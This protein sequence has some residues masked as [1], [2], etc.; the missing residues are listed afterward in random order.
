MPR[1]AARVRSEAPVEQLIAGLTD[2]ELREV[3]S[4]AVDR[5]ADVERQV[6]LIA[7]RGAGDLA[8][9]RAEVDRGLRTRRFLDYGESAGW[10]H[11]AQPLVAELDNAVDASPSRELV[12]LLQRA[13][14]HVVK[15]I[16][17]ADDSDGLIG[18][19][20][21]ELLALHARA[22]DAGVADPVE[23]AAWM[24]RFG[25]DDQDFFEVDPVRY[26]SA[27]GDAG[28]AAYRDA[29]GARRDGDAF[30]VRY[31]RERLAILDRDVDAL[32]KLLGGDLT[33]P[34]QFIRVAEAM[35]EL[36]LGDEALV[37]A[38]R[39]IAQTS[40]WQVSQLYD[41]ACDVQRAEPLEVLALRRAQH[42]RMPSS[43]TYRALRTAA[44]AL[45]A[46]PLEQEAARVTLQRADPR[47]FVDA[48]LSDDE[49]ELA[50]TAAAAAPD[51]ALGSDLW[52]RL[53]ERSERD[54]P[55]DALV[56]YERIADEVL[57]RADRRAYHSA[58]RILQRA[59]AAAQAAG[60]L[61]AFDEYLAGLRE[62]YRRRPT[63]MEILDKAGLR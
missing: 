13:V 40:G 7:A 42:E 15:V 4:A 43:S 12:E 22:C 38:K 49:L 39:G 1:R 8:Q 3:V 63:L 29:A 9:L 53:A 45:D 26:A 14:G 59:R 6:R 55:A 34:Y 44:E 56:V 27:L 5:H 30:A 46:W 33:T 58:A 60:E 47:G 19:L 36:G 23:L 24:V 32:V 21:R 31:A 61:D 16:M 11:A 2:D 10:A 28:L 51:E 17:H 50:W 18:D 35:R 37:W 25:F 54:R 41:L 52:L 48:L 62:R 57:E 20:A